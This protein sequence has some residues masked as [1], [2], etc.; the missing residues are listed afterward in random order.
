MYYPGLSVNFGQMLVDAATSSQGLL[1][2]FY[3][4]LALAMA[5]PGIAGILV[6]LSLVMRIFG[7]G[8][9]ADDD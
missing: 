5:L 8:V 6:L 7:R 9:R 3:A 2:F 1:A 4:P